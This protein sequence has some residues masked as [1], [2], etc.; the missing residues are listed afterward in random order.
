MRTIDNGAM[1]TLYAATHP[2]IETNN[3]NGV[4]FIPSKYLPPPYCRPVIGSINP[5]SQNR[6]EC[7][8]FWELSQRL[9]ELNTTI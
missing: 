2:D 3:Y 1:T 4:Y 5:I 6:E 8:R 7:R 9:T